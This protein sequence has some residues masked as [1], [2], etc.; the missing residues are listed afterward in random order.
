MT[1][2]V[3]SIQPGRDARLWASVGLVGGNQFNMADTERL[4]DFIYGDDGRV[5]LSSFEVAKIL[6]AISRARFDV[7]LC[8]T[9]F[10]TEAGKI[11][12]NQLAHIH[13]RKI[14]VYIL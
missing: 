12:A 6:L 7:L 11:P 2:E 5:P 10:P 9:F 3:N 13:A 1:V 8:Q 14:G 4:S